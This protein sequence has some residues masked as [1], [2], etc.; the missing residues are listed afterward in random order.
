MELKPKYSYLSINIDNS[1]SGDFLE[2]I[3]VKLDE[4]IIP[5]SEI[6]NKLIV[7]KATHKLEIKKEFYKIIK[8]K[9][10]TNI[11][12]VFIYKLIPIK[13]IKEIVSSGE[14]VEVSESTKQGIKNHVTPFKI[15]VTVNNPRTFKFEKDGYQSQDIRVTAKDKVKNIIN[16]KKLVMYKLKI[17][18]E[19]GL[20]ELFIRGEGKNGKIKIKLSE[21][22]NK[23]KLYE[24]EYYIRGEKRF[25]KDYYKNIYVEKNGI[26]HDVPSS[27]CCED[28]VK[29][30][31]GN[32]LKI[33]PIREYDYYFDFP[34]SLI[35]EFNYS[36]SAGKNTSIG[37]GI[38]LL[39]QRKRDDRTIPLSVGILGDFYNKSI[40]VNLSLFK[41]MFYDKGPIFVQIGVYG[42]GD[43]LSFLFKNDKVFL[44]GL[45]S[46]KIG[47]DIYLS[48][49]Y[50]KM[51]VYLKI[52]SLTDT[53]IKRDE[54]ED[55]H[56][57][58]DVTFSTGI[59][60]V[61]GS[62]GK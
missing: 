22:I 57:V 44:N 19:A 45:F 41:W 9:I 16:V 50:I 49:P 62:K 40:T 17:N 27:Q 31:L 20:T 60:F 4:E 1:E 5:W 58:D 32:N 48:Y 10:D 43:E 39:N 35:S 46:F 15:Y 55:D 8:D 33:S 59:S 24:G 25:Y 54:D 21:K 53:S 14:N 34:I 52:A 37:L 36:E 42:L 3:I 47:G 6:N 61:W 38:A 2:D 13:H 30:F 12:E 18:N 56:L 11:K 7:T 26:Y 51:K 23:L 29:V 28:D